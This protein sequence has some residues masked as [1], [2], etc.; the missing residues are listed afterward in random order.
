M[1]VLTAIAMLVSFAGCATGMR[2]PNGP[3]ALESQRRV[4]AMKQAGTYQGPQMTQP[5]RNYAAE[6]L[7]NGTAYL[8]DHWGTQRQPQGAP[9]AAPTCV[10]VP[11]T[12]PQ[13]GMYDLVTQC[14]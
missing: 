9:S 12:N 2:D 6:G 4:E 8:A 10:R 1:K 7:L 5:E 13:T 11:V 3:D 14:K